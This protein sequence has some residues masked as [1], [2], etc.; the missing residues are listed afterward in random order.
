MKQLHTIF[1]FLILLMMAASAFSQ[2]VSFYTNRADLVER[3]EF[4]RWTKE[5]TKAHPKIKVQVIALE[6]YDQEMSARISRGDYGDALLIPASLPAMAWPSYF[7]PLGE[8]VEKNE[9]HFAEQW[10]YAG[11]VYGLALGVNVEGLIYNKKVFTR[12]GLQAPQ[13]L[14][15]LYAVAEKIKRQ[16]LTA[17]ALNIG[18]AWPL[19]QWDKAALLIAKDGDY[20]RELAQDNSPFDLQKPYGK[21]LAIAQK[22]YAEGYSEKQ[23]TRDNWQQ[24][25]RDFAQ[26]GIAMMLMGTWVIPQLLDAGADVE[27]IGFLPFPVSDNANPAVLL[28]V[29]WGVAVNKRSKHP[30]AAKAWLDY[31]VKESDYADVSGYLPIVKKRQSTL[32][33]LSSLQEADVQLIQMAKYDEEFLRLANKAGLDFLQGTSIRN[34]LINPDFKFTLRYW[35]E[36]WKLARNGLDKSEVLLSQ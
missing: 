1:V 22:L 12:L 10:A 7:L 28:N 11:K 34:I 5:F 2:N 4:A 25:K 6:R 18:A 23:I 26:G 29:D 32:P 30:Q 14:N 24:S 33:Q 31:L 13:T 35:N 36:R 19:Q 21:S 15:E 20:F 3:G 16:G 8:V 27:T 9:I 17:F